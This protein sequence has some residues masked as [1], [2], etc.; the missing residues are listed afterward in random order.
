MP[1]KQSFHFSSSRIVEGVKNLVRHGILGRPR[2]DVSYSQSGEDRIIAFLL[3]A[4]GITD[5][6][7]LD[8]GANNPRHLSNTYFFYQLGHRGVCIEPNPILYREFTK[9]RPRDIVLNVGIGAE[10]SESLPFYR[11]GPEADGLSTFSHEHALQSEQTTRFKI[12]Q[13]LEIRVTTVNTILAEYFKAPPSLLSIDVEGLDVP[14]L[15]SYDFEAF[16]PAVICAETHN[17]NG[18]NFSK[19]PEIMDLIQS[20]GYFI[21]ADTFLNTIFLR[22]DY[23]ARYFSVGKTDN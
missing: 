17:G 8:I 3:D 22:S 15:Q 13:T 12:E 21:Y 4:I 11:F 6:T 9:E 2:F 10:T 1:S 19:D 5:P 14:I 23:A 18:T 7:Y 16:A 20:K